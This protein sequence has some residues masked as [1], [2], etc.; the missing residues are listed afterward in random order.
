M[1][2]RVS[3]GGEGS[4]PSRAGR[5]RRSDGFQEEKASETRFERPA[6]PWQSFS[7][8]GPGSLVGVPQDFGERDPAGP[9]WESPTILSGVRQTEMICQLTLKNNNAVLKSHPIMVKSS[10]GKRIRSFKFLIWSVSMQ[11]AHMEGT[12][13]FFKKMGRGPEKKKKALRGEIKKET[14]V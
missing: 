3:R 10:S 14:L 9:S 2:G 11:V 6:K 13:Y 12:P 1:V 5:G 8:C 7:K 4:S